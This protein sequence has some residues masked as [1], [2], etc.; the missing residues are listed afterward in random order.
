MYNYRGAKLSFEIKKFWFEARALNRD[1]LRQFFRVKFL[2]EFPLELKN[3]R[4]LTRW[5]NAI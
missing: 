1:K 3:K 4:D 5:N 2:S